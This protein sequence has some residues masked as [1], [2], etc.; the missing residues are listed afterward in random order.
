MAVDGLGM[1]TIAAR[2]DLPLEGFLANPPRVTPGGVNPKGTYRRPI[3]HGRRRNQVVQLREVTSAVDDA[4]SDNGWTDGFA[5]LE[6]G[7]EGRR[8]G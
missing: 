6:I 1:R 4:T 3:R 5:E 7:V 2:R 8:L